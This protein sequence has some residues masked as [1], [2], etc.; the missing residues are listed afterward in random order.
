ML[1]FHW[2]L[3]MGKRSQNQHST[4]AVQDWT[5]TLFTISIIIKLGGI[6]YYTLGLFV[7][8][9]G[10]QLNSKALAQWWERKVFSVCHWYQ[11][12]FLPSASYKCH[13]AAEYFIR[14]WI[15]HTDPV[16]SAESIKHCLDSISGCISRSQ[17]AS[18]LTITNILLFSDTSLLEGSMKYFS[19][20]PDIGS[21]CSPS[22]SERASW[23]RSIRRLNLAPIKVKGKAPADFSDSK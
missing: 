20:L 22:C 8:P 21:Y 19:P 3:S 1:S 4:W 9:S 16:F 10:W 5:A 12:S 17:A 15:S 13:L 2:F 7:Q 6:S 18:V 11:S 23:E 14:N